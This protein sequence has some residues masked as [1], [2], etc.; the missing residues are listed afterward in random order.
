MCNFSYPK[1]C[2]SPGFPVHHQLPEPAQTHVHRVSD[3]I[4]PFH[5]LSSLSPPIFNLSQHHGL[6]QSQF[7]PSGG[8]SIGASVSASILLMNIQTVFLYYWLV[9][10]PCSL[11]YSQESS[12]IP[13]YKSINS[14]VLSFLYVPVS[15]PLM[16]TG[17][18]KQ[19]K[20]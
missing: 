17:K 9:W 8:Q 20:T 2:H 14:S 18:T 5:P 1:D 12:P 6:F 3:A 19:N 13:Q 4:Q 16:T 11:R 15:H 7:F 10:F